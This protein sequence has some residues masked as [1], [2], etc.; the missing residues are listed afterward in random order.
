MLS[1]PFLSAR[2]ACIPDVF[3]LQSCIHGSVYI[4]LF[5]VRAALICTKEACY[6]QL[7]SPTEDTTPKRLADGAVVKPE[8]CMLCPNRD[9]SKTPMHQDVV[10]EREKEAQPRAAKSR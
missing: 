8:I 1:Q 4:C 10:G 2:S 9:E 5:C 6:F 7:T 3:D